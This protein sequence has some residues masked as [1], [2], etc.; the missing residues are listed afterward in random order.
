MKDLGSVAHALH[1]NKGVYA[2]LIGSGL[3]KAAG[4]PTGWEITLEL[5]REIAV[6]E[7]EDAGEDPSNWWVKQK[8]QEPSYSA[9]LKALGGTPAERRRIV[10]ARIEPT[11][12]EA[13]Q[14]LKRPTPAHQALAQLAAHGYIKVFVTTNFDRL[15]EQALAEAGVEP[16]VI[17]SGDDAKGA[18]PLVHNRVTVL[19]VH[20]DYLDTRIKN[21]EAELSRLDSGISKLLDR[22]FDDFGLIVCGWSGVWDA[23]LRDAILRA[24]NRR[25]SMFWLSRGSPAPE[26]AEIIKAR[27]GHAVQI[28][29]ADAAFTRIADT[30][31]ALEN[32]HQATPQ[33]VATLE[34]LVKKYLVDPKYRIALHDLVVSEVRRV[35]DFL[36]GPELATSGAHPTHQEVSRRVQI[37]GNITERL[38]RLLFVIAY[39]GGAEHSILVRMAIKQVGDALLQTSGFEAYVNARRSVLAYLLYAVTFGCV[40]ANRYEALVAAM[41]ARLGRDGYDERDPVNFWGGSVMELRDSLNAVLGTGY[42][43]P[44]SVQIKPMI[45]KE[46]ERV[47]ISAG[48]A[49]DFAFDQSEMMHCLLAGYENIK[50]D[51]HFWGPLGEFGWKYKNHSSQKYDKWLDAAESEGNHWAPIASG[52]FDGKL[53]EFRRSKAALLE[54][55]GRLSWY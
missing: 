55:I 23:G 40:C 50:L 20:G 12:S 31:D 33:D 45:L 22:V 25:Y 4:V 27:R 10:A 29:D 15:L 17:S 43:V 11:E 52:I 46:A 13:E 24:P 37:S 21:T 32:L 49:F 54:F 51:R 6:L 9:I 26:A 2:V 35:T 5:V 7:G 53:D 28:A 42:F 30:V 36:A 34:A 3:S 41:S 18:E 48:E 44:F 1:S 47:G 16:T 8:G 14:G 19:K 39:H 38:R